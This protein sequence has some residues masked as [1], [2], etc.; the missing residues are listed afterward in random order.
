MASAATLVR[1]RVKEVVE[2]AFSAE[3]YT[4]ENDKLPRAAG[5]DGSAR[6]ACYPEREVESFGDVNVLEIEVVLQVY[7][8][9]EAVP[10]EHIARDP[11]DIEAIADR[12][13]GAFQ[14][15]SNGANPDFWYLR[16]ASV[17]YP[18]DPTGNRTRL[19]ARFTARAQNEAALG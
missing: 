5:R 15:E 2:D 18:D 17:E 16:L 9:Y 4:V 7:L 19:E 1:A 10:D 3:G 13:R 14:T 11:A 6:L 8:A 12:L